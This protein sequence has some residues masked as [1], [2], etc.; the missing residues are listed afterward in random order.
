MMSENKPK[1][2]YNVMR[3]NTLKFVYIMYLYCGIQLTFFMNFRC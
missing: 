3:P 1:L 2:L